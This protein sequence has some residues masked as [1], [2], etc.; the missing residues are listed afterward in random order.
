MS[1]R[2]VVLAGGD[3]SRMKAAGPKALLPVFF[4]PMVHHVLETAAAVS[5]GPVCLVFD[6]GERELREQCRGFKDLVYVRQE[7]DGGAISAFRA[8]EALA[9]PAETNLL[10]LFSDCVL[11]TATSLRGL[12]AQHETSGV[13]CTM[14]RGE[15]S[16][17]AAYCFRAGSL[18]AAL[19]ATPPPGRAVEDLLELAGRGA[20]GYVFAD[21]SEAWDINEPYGLW[22]TERVLAE[23]LNKELMLR[24]V[25]LQDPLTTYIDPRCRI[26]PGVRIEGGCTVVNSVIEAGAVLENGC[27]VLDSEV[28]RDSVLRQGSSV[29][30]SR[31]GRDC[32]VGP[33]ARL[34]AGA[35]LDDDVAVGNFVEIKNATL[36]SGT[37]AAHLS[38][39]GDALVG[40]NVNIGCGFV[41]CNSSGRPL[42]QRT[43]IEDDVFI[44]SASQAIAPVTLGA[45]SFIATGTS[46][47]D[48]VPP[49]SFV[50]SRGRQVTKP[51]YAKKFG[52]PPAPAPRPQ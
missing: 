24:G 14:G 13:A 33:Y 1:A 34:R 26:D 6:R 37:R 11:M 21:P 40:R 30:A 46:V 47:T 32:R 22:R 5:Q 43:V 4:R 18:F 10:I 29:E 20:S 17:A 2:V 45:R 8:L 23:R 50:I 51:G 15:G 19:A 52:A 44:G 16:P 48:D 28:G 27:R 38:F 25:A 49:D 31:V 41:T 42:K 7:I 3:G 35:R 9:V 36:G 39:I 12:I